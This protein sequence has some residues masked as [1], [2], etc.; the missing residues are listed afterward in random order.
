VAEA[1]LEA[2]E[3][4]LEHYTIVAA[5]DGMV[6]WLDV[7]PGTVSRAGT[8]VWGEIVDLSEV[9]VR[10]ELSPAELS[11][12]D[13]TQSAEV[14]QAE[15]QR[16]WPAKFVYVSPLANRETGRVP[17]VFRVSGGAYP[18]RCH[19]NVT[20][21]LKLATEDRNGPPP[22]AGALAAETGDD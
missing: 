19:L 9:D 8:K 21:A 4:E 1:E 6:C 14:R 13:W 11:K 20:V 10:V 15:T 3:E 18:L 17:V 2:A 16:S 12:V 7:T 22:T 5:I